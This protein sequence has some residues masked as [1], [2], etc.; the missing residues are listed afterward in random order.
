MLSDECFVLIEYSVT[1]K[2]NNLM[3]VLI[4]CD[5][6]KNNNYLRLDYIALVKKEILR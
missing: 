6:A 1:G 5:V 2:Q 3:D 4:S